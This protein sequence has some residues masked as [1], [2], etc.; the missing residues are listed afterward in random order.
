MERRRGSIIKL[1]P[2]ALLAITGIRSGIVAII[3]IL[4]G[5][6]FFFLNKLMSINVH[7]GGFLVILAIVG[8][9]IIREI[10]FRQGKS[11]FKGFPLSK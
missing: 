1:I 9:G 11:C 2:W 3:T 6:I 4:A 10:I 7:I 5:I 8:P